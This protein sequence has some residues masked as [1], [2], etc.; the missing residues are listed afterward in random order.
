MIRNILT[1]K[2]EKFRRKHKGVN[3]GIVIIHPEDYY[4]IVKIISKM[5]IFFDI[6]FYESTSVPKGNPTLAIAETQIFVPLT[7]ANHSDYHKKN[8]LA[9]IEIKFKEHDNNI[10]DTRAV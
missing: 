6:K 7:D 3:P 1:D 8:G 4:Q 5:S 2:I 9:S 10:N